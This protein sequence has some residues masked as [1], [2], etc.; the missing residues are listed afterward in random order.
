MIPI[1][2]PARWRN[3]ID[4]PLDREQDFMKD[5]LV[6]ADIEFDPQELAAINKRQ[7]GPDAVAIDVYGARGAVAYR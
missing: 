1:D 4:G 6:D 2:R 7:G 5:D 3:A